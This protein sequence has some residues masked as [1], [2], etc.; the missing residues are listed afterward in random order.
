MAPRD[1]V[2]TLLEALAVTAELTGT[3]LSE[4]AARAMAADLGAYPVQQVLV[5]LT[6]CRRELK[7]RLTIAA[8]LERLDDGRPGPNEAWAMIPQDEAGSVVWTQEM[9]EAFGVASPLLA[10]GQV[11]AARSAFIEYYERA[12]AHARA[13]ILPPRWFPSLGHD[14]KQRAAAVEHAVMKG[15]ITAERANQLLPTREQNVVALPAPA[16]RMPEALRKQ[17]ADFRFKAVE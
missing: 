11:I 12:I 16:E 2:I 17:L 1:S 6:R 5:A 7:G 9:A 3:E 14:P 8:V 15:R 13:E 4:S 10:E